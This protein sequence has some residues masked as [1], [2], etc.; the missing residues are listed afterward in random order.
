MFT[1]IKGQFIAGLV[2]QTWM[3]YATRAQ[4]QLKVS[5]TSGL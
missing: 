2:E 3:D 5:Y 1:E 4:A